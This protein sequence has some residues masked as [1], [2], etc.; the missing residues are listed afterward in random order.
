MLDLIV[1]TDLGHDPDDFFA[2]CYLA[3]VGVR[4]RTIT[5]VPGDRDQLAVAR[6]LVKFLGLDIP[7]GA[8]K[9]DSRKCSSGG[10][11]HDLLDRFGFPREAGHDGPGDEVIAATM[12]KHPAC[13]FLVIGP[14]TS[15]ARYL[16]RPD[17]VV[18]RRL[19]MQGGFL[20]YDLYAPRVRL[21][22]FEGRTWMPTFNLNGDRKG[23]E[24]LLRAPIPDRR[25]V[26]K[27]VCH[28][29]LYDRGFHATMP[30]AETDRP[31]TVLFMAGMEAYLEHHE[32]KKWHD[33]TA[34]A[35]HLH[36]DIGA[37]LRGRV[38]KIEGGWG[39]VPDAGGDLILADIDR[40]ALW[41]SFRGWK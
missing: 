35:C 13:E 7:V 3:G 10:M 33:P 31:A 19:T 16:S 2:I 22:Q 14:C 41:S 39:T 4:I 38:T 15:T 27:N 21:P 40:A 37:W 8:S 5:V 26:G 9:P 11:H 17:A 32:E 12:A 30:P 25:F 6:L 36:P 1:E 29:L 23:A 18:P 28:T 24:V 20:G 34:A